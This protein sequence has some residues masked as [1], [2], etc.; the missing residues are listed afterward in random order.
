LA[1]CTWLDQHSGQPVAPPPIGAPA[2]GYAP[3]AD[4]PGTFVHVP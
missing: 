1:W 3:I 2:K 4:A